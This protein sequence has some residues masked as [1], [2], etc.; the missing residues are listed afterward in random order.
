MVDRKYSSHPNSW[1]FLEPGTI[2]DQYMIE[3]PLADGGFSSVYLARQLSDQYQV[4]IKEYLPRRIAHRTWGNIVVPRTEEKR[5][6]FIRGRKLF[7]EEAKTLATLK[8]PNIVNVINFFQQNST[9]YIVMTYDYGKN[10]AYYIK[11]KKG[12]LTEQFL[13]TVFPIL[14]DGIKLIHLHKLLHLDIKPENIL[15]RA[16][17]DPVLLDFGAVQPYPEVKEWTLGKVLT[18]G[19]SPPEQYPSQGT[20][21][22]WS[23]I[24]AIGASMRTCIEGSPP[25]PAPE[26]K[27]NDTMI[28]AVKAFKRKYSHE[29][30]EVIDWATAFDPSSR[31]Q[32]IDDFLAAFPTRGS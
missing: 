11:N 26:R 17:G 18:K 3:R 24:Y 28:P 5:S 21:G 7:I 10:L 30:L 22:P 27:T 6:L 12:S 4:V 2:I 23:D 29:L 15:I 31:P 9:V 14:L 16:G 13:L 32:S 19:F 20:V 8:H 25:P 1:N